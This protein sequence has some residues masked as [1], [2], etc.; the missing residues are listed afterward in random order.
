VA[1]KMFGQASDD[2]YDRLHWPVSVSCVQLSRT[3]SH[4]IKQFRR[5]PPDLITSRRIAWPLSKLASI[6]ILLCVNDTGPGEA[7][8]VQTPDVPQKVA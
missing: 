3:V 5:A 8:A 2:N 7:L 1:E 6:R 4:K